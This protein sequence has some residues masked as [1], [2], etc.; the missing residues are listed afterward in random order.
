MNAT[1]TLPLLAY[2][3]AFGNNNIGMGS[4]VAM[5][6]TLFLIVT[7]GLYYWIFNPLNETQ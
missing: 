6:M 3:E 7:F 1:E 2:R 4:T 5:F